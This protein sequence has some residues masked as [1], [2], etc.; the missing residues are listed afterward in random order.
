MTNSIK[1]L[2]I[3]ITLFLLIVMASATYSKQAAFTMGPGRLRIVLV[4]DAKPVER[5]AAELF[6]AEVKLRTGIVVPILTLGRTMAPKELNVDGKSMRTLLLDIAPTKID[7]FKKDSA[8]KSTWTKG[9]LQWDG[10][11]ILTEPTY[12]GLMFVRGQSPSGLVAAMGRLLRLCLYQQHRLTIP[13]INKIEQPELDTRGMYFATHFYNFYHVA[14]L[15]EVDAIIEELALWGGNNLGVCWDMHHFK[16]INDPEAQALLARLRHFADTAHNVGMKFMLVLLANGA[17]AD[18]PPHLRATRARGV[19]TYGVELCPSKPEGMALIGKWQSEVFAAF[20]KVDMIL[21]WPYDHGGCACE[22]CRVWGG[23][24]F[25]KASKQLSDIYRQRFPNGKV[26]VSTWWFDYHRERGDF[27]TFFDYLETKQP[28]WID[29]IVGGKASP[30]QRLFE[31][32]LHKRYPLVWFPEISMHKMSPWGEH[33]ANPLPAFCAEKMTEMRG[34]IAGAWPYS[35]GRYEDLNKFLWTRYYWN[36]GCEVDKSLK[37][38]AHYYLSPEVADEAITLFHLLERTHKRN[39]WKVQNLAQADEAFAI[40]ERIDKRLPE[41][42]RKSWR[43]RIIYIRAAIDSILKNQGYMTKE[44]QAALTPL[45]D[46]L[47]ALYYDQG[48]SR[49]IGPPPLP[50]PPNPGNLAFGKKVEV[51][52]TSIRST[53]SRGFAD[54]LTDGITGAFDYYNYWAH[55][56]SKEETAT[57]TIDLGKSLAIREA[58][59]EYRRIKDVYWFIAESLLFEVS[60]DGKTWKKALETKEVPKEGAPYERDFWS[61]PLNTNGRYLRLQLGKSQKQNGYYAG[62]LELAEIEVYGNDEE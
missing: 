6:A 28:D 18:S 41:W 57:I 24:G 12:K 40:T 58:R 3:S 37:E 34:K 45:R 27:R 62:T 55:D 19:A 21:S 49:P 11:Y 36:T 42:S 8:G 26:L 46:E 48:K 33:G 47:L 4:K 61:Y 16:C 32:P 30:Y 22:A 10:Y 9:K 35:E 23:N 54:S 51:S 14:P 56:A 29:G 50:P 52:S 59:L 15:P 25:M 20:P 60:D 17:Y 53:T 1:F 31:R 5:R 44:A 13:F 7:V 43:W 38:Y 39:K 2:R